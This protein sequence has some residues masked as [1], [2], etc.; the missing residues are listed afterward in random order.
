MH[1]TR[2]SKR[3]QNSRSTGWKGAS[4]TTHTESGRGKA[5]SASAASRAIACPRSTRPMRRSASARRYSTHKSSSSRSARL[6]SCGSAALRCS[7]DAKRAA[8][9]TWASSSSETRPASASAQSNAAR[10][11]PCRTKRAA[12]DARR[13]VGR[14]CLNSARAMT[15][16]ITSTCAMEPAIARPSPASSHTPRSQA[17]KLVTCVPNTPP[18]PVAATCLHR[19]FA[20]ATDG[21]STTS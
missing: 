13:G 20:R 10:P 1:E 21:H 9:A 12:A 19:A 8:G 14:R 15:E 11:A 5:T 2:P 3:C 6:A 17:A 4:P 16:P 18:A 7:G